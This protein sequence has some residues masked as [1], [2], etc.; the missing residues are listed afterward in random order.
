VRSSCSP[1]ET[2]AGDPAV[3]EGASENMGERDANGAGVTE[4]DNVAR[5]GESKIDGWQAPSSKAVAARTVVK[6]A[7]IK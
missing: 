3:G 5:R 6:T 7:L 2:K 4:A 1:F